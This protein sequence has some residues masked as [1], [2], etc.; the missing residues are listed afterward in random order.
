MVRLHDAARKGAIGDVQRLL[1]SGVDV[2]REDE[3]DEFGGSPLHLAAGGGH[4]VVVKLLLAAGARPNEANIRGA[5]PLHWATEH[6]HEAVVKVLL[7]AGVNPDGADRVGFTPLH[8]ASA[9]GHVA[10]VTL[11]LSRGA[12]PT[13]VN[14]EGETAL[15]LA[16]QNGHRAVAGLLQDA[17][18]VKRVL[19]VRAKRATSNALELTCTTLVGNTAATIQWPDDMPMA[20]LPVAIIKHVRTAGFTG[21]KEPLGTWNLCLIKP[22]GEGMP[23]A[24]GKEAPSLCEQYGLVDVASEPA[25]GSPEQL[26][27]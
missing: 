9:E 1:K 27:R 24:V 12:N 17:M 26:T 8:F 19:T 14:D 4:E 5:T 20:E 7:D 13:L 3:S 11:L 6:G 25:C 22:G 10:A 15:D 21:L 2:N 16:E 23:L 18:E